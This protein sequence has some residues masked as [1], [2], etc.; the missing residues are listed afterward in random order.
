MDDPLATPGEQDILFL[1]RNADGTYYTCGGPQ[2]RF[3][4]INGHVRSNGALPIQL[5]GSIT[6]TAFIQAIQRA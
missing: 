2:G 3:P 1:H 5:T 6:D 4:V